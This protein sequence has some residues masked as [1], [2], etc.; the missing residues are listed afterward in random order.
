MCDL[1]TLVWS[2]VQKEPIVCEAHH[3]D[4]SSGDTLVADLRVCGV[5]QPQ[6]DVLFDMRAVD[7]DAPSYQGRTPQAVLRTAETE[8]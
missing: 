3:D 8:K 4:L 2:Q 6:V 5:W 7:T 1:A